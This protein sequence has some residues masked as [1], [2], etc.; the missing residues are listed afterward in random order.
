MQ[1]PGLDLRGRE[2]Y[3]LAMFQVAIGIRYFDCRLAVSRLAG[4]P[5]R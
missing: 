5:R 2:D 1:S 3:R 4:G